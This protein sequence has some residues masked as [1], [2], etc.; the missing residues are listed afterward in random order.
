MP[1]SAWMTSQSIQIVRS[2]SSSSFVTARSDRPMSRWISCV[3]PPTFPDEASRVVRVVVARG[4]MP[5]SA[6]TQPLP[7]LRRNGGTR[8]STLAVQITLVRPASMST[9]PSGCIRYCG[10]IVTGRRSPAPRLSLRVMSCLSPSTAAAFGSGRRRSTCP[11]SV[12]TSC[13]SIRICTDVMAGRFVVSAETMA[14]TVRIS[15][16][17]PPGWFVRRLAAEID[18]GVAALADEQP[19]QRRCPAGWPTT[20]PAGAG[21]SSASTIR[22]RLLGRRPRR[23]A[24]R[25]PPR[26]GEAVGGDVEQRRLDAPARPRPASAGAGRRRRR[27]ARVRA[28]RDSRTVAHV[29]A[30]TAAAVIRVSATTRVGDGHGATGRRPAACASTRPRYRTMASKSAWTTRFLNSSDVELRFLLRVAEERHLDEHRRHVRRDEHAERRLLDRV[31][32]H[33]DAPPQFLLDEHRR[34]PPTRSGAGPGPCPTG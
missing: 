8:S 28:G 27:Q 3:R 24:R 32:A 9:E 29:P 11:A 22:L 6:V 10:V 14:Y 34:T 21:S 12:S 13:P 30:P 25:A 26:R 16:A 2:P 31:R 19:A 33:L 1:P 23:T 17:D 4:S 18:V 20:R 7:L 5:Y 15:L